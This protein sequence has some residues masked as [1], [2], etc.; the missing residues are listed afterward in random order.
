VTRSTITRVAAATALLYAAR[1]F[2]RN[3]GTTKEESRMQLPG[4]ELVDGPVVQTTEGVWIDASA[5][6][7]WP[8]LVQMGQDRGG[9]YSYESLENFFGLQYHN[10]DRIHPEWQRLAAGDLVRL[11][12]KGWMG[13]REG[14][15]LT[16]VDV[17]EQKTIVLRTAASDHA[18]D[19]VWSFHLTRHWED[20]CRLLI[21]S[22]TRVRHPGDAL[23]LELASPANALVTRGMLRAIK[24]RAEG[25]LQAATPYGA[26]SAGIH[27]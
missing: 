17:V 18:L 23:A 21:R 2:Y 8:W 25:Q 4:D 5:G 6:A 13:M 26:T 15:A 9:L 12:P 20:R 27:T 24:R 3:W 10:A 7:V 19:A 11:T 16:V 14:I 1:R 22:R